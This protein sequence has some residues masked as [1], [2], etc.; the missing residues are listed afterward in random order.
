MTS[1]AE[2]AGRIEAGGISLPLESTPEG[3]LATMTGDGRDSIAWALNAAVT[4]WLPDLRSALARGDEVV[5][6][7]I[8]LIRDVRPDDLAPLRERWREWTGDELGDD[9]YV[10]G[11]GFAPTVAVPRPVLIRLLDQL[12]ALRDAAAE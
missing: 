11:S 4:E 2:D 8:V 12:A 9:F 6:D 1:R 7:P 10:V 5:K 3:V